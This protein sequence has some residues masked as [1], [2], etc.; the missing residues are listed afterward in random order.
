MSGGKR[1]DDHSFWG[2]S[3]PSGSV[4]PMGSKM[5]PMKDSAGDG[6]EPYYED[7]AEAIHSSQEM[8]MRKAKGHS[9]KDG[10]RN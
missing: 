9:M 4:L 7:T 6:H 5:K 1:L 3:K 8:N 10:Y 2:G